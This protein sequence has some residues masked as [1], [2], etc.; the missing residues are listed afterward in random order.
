MLPIAPT[1][2]DLSPYTALSVH[3]GNPSLISLEWLE[4][5]GWL[6]PEEV[7]INDVAAYRQQRLI[8]AH[9]GYLEQ[10][11][12]EDKQDYEYFRIKHD[13]WLKDYALFQAIRRHQDNRH[14]LAWPEPLRDCEPAAL[15]EV[16]AL[17]FQEI[18]QI[19]SIS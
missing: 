4:T 18:E 1:H 10:G 5:K 11:A 12:E 9:E 19:C 16:Q 7:S 2:G 17:L 6:E 15:R 8:A 13:H 3:A 14:W